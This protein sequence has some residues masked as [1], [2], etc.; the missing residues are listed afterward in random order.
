MTRIARAGERVAPIDG[1]NF[2]YTL[3]PSK[4]CIE[5]ESCFWT[6]HLR[7]CCG[8][9]HGQYDIAKKNPTEDEL[10]KD[11]KAKYHIVY[12]KSLII[13]V[14]DLFGSRRLRRADRWYEDRFPEELKR[15][16]QIRNARRAELV[17]RHGR[18]AHPSVVD[19]VCL[20]A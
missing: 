15:T 13:T 4:H 19:T 1:A 7:G 8:G 14:D 20:C 12:H 2:A 9:V 5:E 16:V 10:N 11:R 6:K 18:G 3:F 17:R